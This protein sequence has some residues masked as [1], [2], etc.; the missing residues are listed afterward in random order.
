MT[1][2]EIF[3]EKLCSY[4]TVQSSIQQQG[5]ILRPVVRHNLRDT[6]KHFLDWLHRAAGGKINN[7]DDED[8]SL[9]G[10]SAV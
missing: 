6:V 5:V 3:R 2:H 4:A 9:L 10:Y 1:S 8:E 7:N